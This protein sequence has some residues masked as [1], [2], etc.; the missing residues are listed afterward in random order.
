MCPLNRFNKQRNWAVYVHPNSGK[1]GEDL[2]GGE[3]RRGG[4]ERGGEG[5]EG[6]EGYTKAVYQN[7]D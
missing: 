2:G 5:G 6:G 1:M 3:E 4:E 7:I